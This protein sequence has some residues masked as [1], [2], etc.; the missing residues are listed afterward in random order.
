MQTRQHV[1]S[2]KLPLILIAQLAFFLV[3]WVLVPT[4][5]IYLKRLRATDAEIGILI[6]AMSLASVVSR[7]LVGRALR[8]ERE[9]LFMMAGAIACIVCSV[10]YLVIPPFWPMLP[11][12]ILQGVALGLFHTSTT[13]YVANHTDPAYRARALAHLTVAVNVAS[14]IAPPLGMAIVN[15]F[16]F[17]HLFLA[18]AA[19][20]LGALLLS[21]RLGRNELPSLQASP[22]HNGFPLD[23]Q[24]F[25]PSLI[26]FI[27]FIIWASLATFYPLY[28]TSLGVTNPGFFFT[29]IA[30]MCILTR[31][32]GGKI[33]N[34]RNRE[35][36][37]GACIALNAVALTILWLSKTQVMFLIV[38]LL[39]GAGQ[40]FLVP[41]MLAW[42]LDRST[43]PSAVVVATMYTSFDTG[44]FLGPLA[45]GVVA[46]YMGYSAVFLCLPILGAISL[47]CL[48]YFIASRR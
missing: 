42:A 19:G 24:S 36:V 38:A 30:V 9:K 41:A 47:L 2:Q 40:G 37:V 18:S 8:K 48:S 10:A 17:S 45:M 28:A 4:L 21:S 43:S 32:L 23:R 12:R 25:Q 39:W 22:I 26:G 7:P 5:P 6:G 27:G 16:G 34:I 15:R 1:I 44:Q 31:G 29:A 11:V 3:I 14:T 13:T 33:L 35:A 46:Q 20:S